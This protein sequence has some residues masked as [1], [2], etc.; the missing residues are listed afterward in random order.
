MRRTVLRL[1]APCLLLFLATSSYAFLNVTV[2]TVDSSL[3]SFYIDTHFADYRAAGGD[4][5]TFASRARAFDGVNAVESRTTSTLAVWVRD[6]AEKLQGQIVGVPSA[7]PPVDGYLLE[8]GRGID[9]EDANGV[10]LERHTA[11]DLGLG[12]GDQLEIL[13][14]GGV[15]RVHVRGVASSP[16]Y[17]VAAASAQ[18]L[19]TARGSFAVVFVPQPL[20]A[21]LPGPQG[22]PEV[23][24]R[25]E[26]GADGAALDRRLDRLA[27]DTGA[28]LRE[29][30]ASQPSNAMVSAEING[31]KA[32][33]TLV[34][35]VLLLL[36]LAIGTFALGALAPSPRAARI[37][38]TSLGVGGLVGMLVAIAVSPAITDRLAIPDLEV[39]VGWLGLA[40]LVLIS[41]IAGQV[42]AEVAEIDHTARTRFG[43]VVAAFG[44]AA[45][46]AA[47]IVAPLGIVDSA[48]VTLD[49]AQHLERV[50]AQVAFQTTVGEA[51]LAQ[52]RGI[53][54]VKVAE[55]VPSANV[56]I[57]HGRERYLT[58]IE[59]FDRDTVLQRFETPSGAPQRLPEEGVLLPSRL[60]RLLDAKPGD[61]VVITIPGV[62]DVTMDVAAFTS[63]ALGNLVFTSTPALRRALG[64]QA[65]T[66]AGGLFAVAA[67]GFEPGA[68]AAAVQRQ[69][70]ALTDVAT[71][72]NV[73]G[74]VGSLTSV[75]PLFDIVV[76]VLAVLGGLLALA[77]FATAAYLVPRGATS[78][79][80]VALELALPS[81]I[82]VLAGVG[83]GAIVA[84][85]LVDSLSTPLVQLDHSLDASTVII[86]IVA[87][88]AAFA[89][90]SLGAGRGTMESWSPPDSAS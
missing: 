77:G 63:D 62:S 31:L 54:G 44:G 49:A 29:P 75:L 13:G 39:G 7:H 68:D 57:G 48:E 26:S 25:Y 46:G 30:R 3:D 33:R 9:P 82:G 83:L 15:Q 38:A 76:I 35:G 45:L 60:A 87:V 10:V 14:L 20:A 42:A 23:L 73:E 27:A 72:V 17:V 32:A 21:R 79:R 18:Q 86:A 47:V 2:A 59:A 5:E 40:V 69:V 85:V 43:R 41:A 8:E 78:R 28:S 71:Y 1:L 64:A 67:A 51:Q 61:Q 6:G 19:V 50:D 22:I 53:D 84:R 34:P 81:G 4:T 90:V 66:F 55:P 52:L 58:Q 80:G 56:S 37:G 24:V 16:E 11:E 88:S 89:L 12:P 65:D 74:T 36:A 70:S